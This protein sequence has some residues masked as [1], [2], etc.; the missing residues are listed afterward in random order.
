MGFSSCQAVKN[1]SF[2]CCSHVLLGKGRCSVSD[3]IGRWKGIV[4][5]SWNS[6]TR[7]LWAGI[8]GSAS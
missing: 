6:R 1:L 5:K 4:I 8:P 7:E 2:Y 3:G